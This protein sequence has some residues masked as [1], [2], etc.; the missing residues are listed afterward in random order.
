MVETSS[1]ACLLFDIFW[2]IFRVQL[3]ILFRISNERWKPFR[4]EMQFW[5]LS[6]NNCWDYRLKVFP[7]FEN[8]GKGKESKW[9]ARNS[10]WKKWRKRI[11]KTSA[12]ARIPSARWFPFLS[13]LFLLL[14]LKTTT[15]NHQRW[16]CD[17]LKE[18]VIFFCFVLLRMLIVVLFCALFKGTLL[19]HILVP[20]S[21]SLLSFRIWFA[22]HTH[23]PLVFSYSYTACNIWWKPF[24]FHVSC[25][26][27]W[28]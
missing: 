2:P 25:H 5:L 15:L 9:N 11:N 10:L 3:A 16:E 12:K 27:V 4:L 26:R 17:E 28:N 21:V 8:E 7:R 18:I 13:H 22:M 14:K 20:V 19:W 23:T 1:F 24:Y 6:S